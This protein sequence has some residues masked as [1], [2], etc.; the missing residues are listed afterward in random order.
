ME[1]VIIGAGGFA[2]EIK[3]ALGLNDIKF[4]VDDLLIEIEPL[5]RPA[6]S[7]SLDSVRQL[8]DDDEISFDTA[9]SLNRIICT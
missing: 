7:S 9:K 1:K 8:L 2:R 5:I 3:S 4:F 6:V